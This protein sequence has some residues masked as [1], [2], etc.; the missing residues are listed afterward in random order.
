MSQTPENSSKFVGRPRHYH[1]WPEERRKAY[2]RR[3]HLRQFYKMS[4]EEY[5]EILGWQDAVCCIC[6]GTNPS[7]KRLAV[8]HDHK[9]GQT[10][11]LL[12][13]SCNKG[14]GLFK[15]NAILLDNARVYIEAWQTEG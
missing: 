2:H 6:G 4:P 7:G 10:R 14:L 11:N 9:T 12:C 8:D 1:L 3:A 13:N 5:D 15:D